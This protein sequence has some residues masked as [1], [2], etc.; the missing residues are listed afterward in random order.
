[1]LGETPQTGPNCSMLNY[2]RVRAV[3]PTPGLEPWSER[4]VEILTVIRSLAYD[5]KNQLM[6]GQKQPAIQLLRILQTYPGHLD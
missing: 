3:V 2:A 6:Q 1:M 5:V 4:Y